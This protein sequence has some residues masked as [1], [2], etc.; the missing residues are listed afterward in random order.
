[1]AAAIAYASATST[2]DPGLKNAAAVNCGP[3]QYCRDFFH[4]NENLH[5]SSRSERCKVFFIMPTKEEKEAAKLAKEEEK[6]R[7]K[8]E[9]EAAKLAK[10]CVPS[11]NSHRVNCPRRTLAS[12]SPLQQFVSGHP[13]ALPNSSAP[14]QR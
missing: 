9:K 3:V 8:A 1:M 12:L 10:V 5:D 14:A 13:E 6:N 11:R 4:N 7:K 2:P